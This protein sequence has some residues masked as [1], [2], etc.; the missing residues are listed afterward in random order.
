MA[1]KLGLGT[2]AP[3]FTLKNQKDE[4]VHLA[5]LIGKKLIVLFFYPADS[6]AGCTLEACAFRDSYQDFT[7][8]G[9]EVI[10]ISGGTTDGKAAFARKNRLPFILL[11]DPDRAVADLYDVNTNFF[12]IQDRKTFVID[13]AGIIRHVFSSQMGVFKHT[14]EALDIIKKLVDEAKA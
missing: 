9:A 3:D 14:K 5:D 12:G 10:G 8:A 7:D 1:A 11:N 13:S 6:S 2:P 4:S